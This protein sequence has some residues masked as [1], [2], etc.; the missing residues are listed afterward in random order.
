MRSALGSTTISIDQELIGMAVGVPVRWVPALMRLMTRGG[1]MMLS[2]LV[3][4]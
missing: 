4:P 2:A 1:V 3:W